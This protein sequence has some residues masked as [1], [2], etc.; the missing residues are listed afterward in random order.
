MDWHALRN[1]LFTVAR[2]RRI[3]AMID[4]F[5]ICRETLLWF[6]IRTNHRRIIPV[7]KRISARCLSRRG[8]IM[9]EI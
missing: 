2:F 1:G 9:F 6:P 3:C 8:C 7:A 4:T 5:S